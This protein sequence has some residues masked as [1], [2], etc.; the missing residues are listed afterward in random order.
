MITVRKVVT[1]STTK[2]A[3][4]ALQQNRF[5][6]LLGGGGF[7]RMGSKNITTLIDLSHCG[8]NKIIEHDHY[9]EI[10]GM[11][12]LGELERHQ[13]L[14]RQYDGLL[15]AA[16]R[17]IVGVQMRNVVTVGASVYARYGFSDLITGLLTLPVTLGLHQG[18]EPSLESFLLEGTEGKELLEAIFIEKGQCKASFTSFRK[19]AGDYAVLNTASAVV[20]GQLKISV[21]ARPG[22]AALAH[23]AMAF[24][25]QGIEQVGDS[26]R[27]HWTEMDMKQA[28]EMAAEELRFGTNSRGSKEYRRHLCKGQVEKVLQ[29]SRQGG[30]LV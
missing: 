22:R 2:E 12:T 10:R 18:K 29:R 14:N 6:T 7:L 4:E 5:A 15:A 1:P 9:W 11:V 28:A 13:E 24:L 21:G 20:K 19:T 25:Q 26:W 27:I 8:L 16:V 3:F 23:K 17:E 30:D